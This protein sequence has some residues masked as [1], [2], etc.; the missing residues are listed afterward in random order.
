MMDVLAQA[1][2]IAQAA[3]RGLALSVNSQDPITGTVGIKNNALPSG[4][5]EL[6]AFTL[7]KYDASTGYFTFLA[8]T[9]DGVTYIVGCALADTM[10]AQGSSKNVILPSYA[11]P[12]GETMTLDAF[13]FVTPPPSKLGAY[14]VNWGSGS[15]VIGLNWTDLQV[16]LPTIIVSKVFSAVITI[17]APVA[18]AEIT[19]F[20]LAKL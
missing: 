1:V 18:P 3:V 20:N 7:G 17:A 10:P 14:A 9:A 13:V 8:F 15:R 16:V 11:V 19:A 12:V 6:V 5:S 2:E 4:A